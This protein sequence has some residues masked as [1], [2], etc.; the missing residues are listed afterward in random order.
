[1]TVA[2]PKCVTKITAVFEAGGYLFLLISSTKLI[3]AT[4]NE[5]N[6][7]NVSKVTYI[8]TTSPITR[9]VKKTYASSIVG[10]SAT[11][12]SVPPGISAID[13]YITRIVECQYHY[14]KR[15]RFFRPLSLF[16]KTEPF[17]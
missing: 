12:Y 15:G 3:I 1:M 7:N 13:K 8:G 5:Q 4:I 6:R 14:A 10:S 2:S 16:L 17:T 11:V 9:K